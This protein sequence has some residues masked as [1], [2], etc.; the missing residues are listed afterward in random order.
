MPID[1][2]SGSYTVEELVAMILENART[3]ASDFA[4]TLLWSPGALCA[5]CLTIGHVSA[6]AIRRVALVQRHLHS[7]LVQLIG[8]CCVVKQT[9]SRRIACLEVY[10][11]TLARSSRIGPH[12]TQHSKTVM[13]LKSLYVGNVLRQLECSL[14]KRDKLQRLAY[15]RSTMK[16]N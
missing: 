15:D 9:L 4:G 3:L 12:M 1:F 6:S 11:L 5:A 13:Q 2:S 16:G 8:A 14:A 7:P 10:S